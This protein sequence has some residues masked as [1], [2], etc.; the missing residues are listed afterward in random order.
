MPV[1]WCVYAIRQAFFFFESQM[2]EL[3]ELETTRLINCETS[4]EKN[5]H[6]FIE[7]GV[8][9]LEIRDSRLYRQSHNTFEA[10]CRERWDMTKTRANQLIQSSEVMENLTTI[11]VKPTHESQVRPLAGLDPEQQREVWRIASNGNSQPTAKEVKAVVQQITGSDGVKPLRNKPPKEHDAAPEVISL[12]DQGLTHPEISKQT[13]VPRRQVRHIVEEEAIRRSVEPQITPEMLSMP[14]REK[15]ER[16]IVQE[17]KR[18]G[19]EFHIIVEQRVNERVKLALEGVRERLEEQRKLSEGI[20]KR[21]DGFIK[22]EIWNL[23]V[24][25]IH[26]DKF[27]QIVSLVN[28]GRMEELSSLKACH[29]D[30]FR[31]FKDFEKFLLN[32]KES[33]TSFAPTLPKTAAEWD[34]ARA[35]ATAARKAARAAK[36]AQKVAKR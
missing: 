29:S 20:I 19:K 30:A 25:C 17:K 36:G 18:L 8:A 21:R 15:L 5:L 28:D 2:N 24:M 11:V 27:D 13:G 34:A 4:I 23:I 3:T 9:L 22:K 12:H 1:G 33:P 6:A 10:Y 35:A 16:A 26:P 31:M 32:E 14:Q 7:V